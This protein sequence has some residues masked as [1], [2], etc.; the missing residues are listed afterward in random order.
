MTN[1]LIKPDQA[2]V[3]VGN[4]IDAI[5]N[6]CLPVATQDSQNFVQA[7]TL[8]SGIKALR[9]I[10][11]TDKNIQA[12]VESMQNTH[13]GF[14]TDRTDLAVWKSKQSGNKELKPYR[15]EDIAEVCIEAM[16]KGYRITNNEFNMI[17]G[18]F[19]AAK[20]GKFRRIQECEGI[21][22]FQFT[23]TSP[24]YE[25]EQGGIQYAK[26]QGFASWKKDGQLTTLGS[27]AEA[28]DKLVF[29]IRVNKHMGEDAIVGKALSK[30]FSRV[31]MRLEGKI[32]PEATDISDGDIVDAEFDA[33]LPGTNDVDI[34][35][36]IEDFALATQDIFTDP[37]FKTWMKVCAKS[38]E[39]TIEKVKA[40][41]MKDIDGF[42]NG[43]ATWKKAQ[44][45]QPEK[46]ADTWGIFRK[47]WINLKSGFE[48]FMWEEK[49]QDLFKLAETED[50]DLYNEGRDKYISQI[51]KAWPLDPTV[52]DMNAYRQK[53]QESAEAGSPDADAGGSKG[54]EEKDDSKPSKD[55]YQSK[56]WQ[57]LSMLKEK[58]PDE[59]VEVVNIPKVAKY[60][61]S[62]NNSY[63]D[64]IDWIMEAIAKIDA[65]V[66]KNGE[67][68]DA[69]IPEGGIP[70]GEIPDGDEKF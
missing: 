26:V 25:K 22:D 43:F 18:R 1:Q 16:L 11:L 9:H 50:P 66:D 28:E 6:E 49:N 68:V 51:G 39:I 33:T 34:N 42:K 52:E 59:Y 46:P 8:A 12:T 62:P 3:A 36:T 41:A 29:K 17:A 45:K 55:V 70:E 48:Q 32:M 19:Y 65:K 15:Y 53:Q 20:N 69:E 2:I 31:L 47:K 56:E 61:D 5:V 67:V 10:F 63:G 27:S 40:E 4:Q 30:L 38:N 7:L 21:T 23:T 54:R 37:L 24:S 57:E 64:K 35:Q 44:K 60:L 13:L 14:M 58:H